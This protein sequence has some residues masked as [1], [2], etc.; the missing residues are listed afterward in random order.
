E[1]TITTYKGY[2]Y[3]YFTNGDLNI[4][5]YDSNNSG[6]VT[7]NDITGDGSHLN[8]TNKVTAKNSSLQT[9]ISTG[10]IYFNGGF[11]NAWT[12]NTPPTRLIAD[13]VFVSTELKGEGNTDLYIESNL[14][15]QNNI[16]INQNS[17][18]NIYIKNDFDSN[19]YETDFNNTNATFKIEGNSTFD[20]I[21][22]HLNSS[23]SLITLGD[24]YMG[25]SG[26]FGANDGPIYVGGFLTIDEVQIS[27][28]GSAY[29]YI[30]NTAT[31][32]DYIDAGIYDGNYDGSTT[33]G[34]TGNHLRNSD[35][36]PDS[37][38]GVY[39]SQGGGQIT[40]ASMIKSIDD[41]EADGLD[42]QPETWLPITLIEF[43]AEKSDYNYVTI[44]WTT[45][46]E[47]NNEYFTLYRSNNGT[48][49]TPITEIAGAGN[50]HHKIEYSYLDASYYT[51]VSYYR[52][53]QTDYDGTR[54][55]S[56][57][58][59]IYN[60]AENVTYKFIDNTVDITFNDLHTRYHVMIT[61]IDGK[62]IYS[63]GFY[64]TE[65]TT[66]QLPDKTG[67][68]IISTLSK[69]GIIDEKFIR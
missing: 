42:I 40:N 3:T 69:H 24:S 50:S 34:G 45:E 10:N 7:N 2:G 63:K 25:G 41:A 14:V 61:S 36:D 13:T 18:G 64:N 30:G 20:D 35:N 9:N 44:Y 22:G 47:Q 51:G 38:E 29:G 16:I 46:T 5:T 57:I 58:I 68:F 27:F 56:K 48:D 11:E 37:N 65:K 33:I 31:S 19:G 23:A 4:T 17:D 53:S 28:Q 62:I 55:F 39:H 54:K 67:I 32:Q 52:L 59:A 21:T 49:F 8:F 43:Y 66:I 1:T 15:Q 60:C 12:T 26:T 6:S